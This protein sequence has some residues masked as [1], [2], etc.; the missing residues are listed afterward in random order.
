MKRNSYL[1]GMVSGILISALVLGLGVSAL[2]ARRS[3]DVDDN[4]RVTINGARFLPKDAQGNQVPL[5]NYGGTIYGPIRAVCEAAGLDVTYVAD[6]NT[7]RLTTSDVTLAGDPAA[8]TYITPARARE[9]ALGHAGVA[10]ADAVFLKTRLDWDDGRMEYEVEFYSGNVEY[11]YDLDAVTGAILSFDHDLENYDI[12]DRWDDHDDHD[13]DDHRYDDAVAGSLITA[14]YARQIALAKAP[15]G[16]TVVKCEL[17]RDDGRYVYE[18]E[19]RSGRTEYECDINAV[20]GVILDW[21]VDHD[22]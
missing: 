15:A 20:T 6:Q 8:S 5:F 14:D 4:V 19:L 16:A 3:I 21:E 11:D 12:H 10:A 18:V 9:I 2:A 17:D 7:A 22:D 13:D 1:K